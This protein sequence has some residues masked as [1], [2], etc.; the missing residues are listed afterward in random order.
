MRGF[1]RNALKTRQDFEMMQARAAEG[2]LRPRQVSELRRHWQSLLD[3]RFAYQVDRVLEGDE[4]PDGQEPE[5]RV[6]D[7]TEDD[8]ETIR[9]VQFKRI[10]SDSSRLARMSFSQTEVEHAIA[11]LEG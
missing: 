6:V 3:G 7:E 1:P 2:S 9:R 5:Y 10:E 11:E 4:E 8:G